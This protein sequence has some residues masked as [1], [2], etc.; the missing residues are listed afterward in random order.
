MGVNESERRKRQD[1]L[2]NVAMGADTRAVAAADEPGR[3]LNYR[4]VA[5]ADHRPGGGREF[6]TVERLAEE[7]ARLVVTD[8]AGATRCG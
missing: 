4:S 3:R 6:H 7:I 8:H 1:I 5:K 2:I